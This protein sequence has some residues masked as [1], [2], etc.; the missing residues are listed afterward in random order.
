MESATR[1]PLSLTN[2]PDPAQGT[3]WTWA[4]QSAL[5]TSNNLYAECADL[6]AEESSRMLYITGY[7]SFG[8]PAGSTILGAKAEV[9]CKASVA[10]PVVIIAQLVVGN[11]AVGDDKATPEVEL[12]PLA[13]ADTVITFGDEDDTWA[14]ALDE[15]EVEEGSGFGIAFQVQNLGLAESDVL[16]DSAPL[17]IYWEP[18]EDNMGVT[19]PTTDEVIE[20]GQF[21]RSYFPRTA[22][23]QT[24]MNSLIQTR[25]N[26]SVSWVRLRMGT[27]A[28]A[29]A[30]GDLADQ[31]QTAILYL[32]CSKLWQ[33]VKNVMDA[34]DEETLP[35]EFVEPEQAAANR[36]YY[37]D[38]ALEILG[39]VD[40][41]EPNDALSG[42][43]KPYFNSAGVADDTGALL[44]AWMEAV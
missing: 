27:T 5:A 29:A 14:Y 1:S 36:D 11:V 19:A 18:P 37:R 24:L 43:V 16:I 2:A 6:A 10:G 7:G 4:D 31:A 17:T 32:T 20:E 8:I 30:T 23:S 38:M 34:Y 35:P 42:F 21:K 44:D 39:L 13:L 26:D 28:Y 33:V 15:N 3:L 25:I 12:D 41:A 9:E 40:T 22:D